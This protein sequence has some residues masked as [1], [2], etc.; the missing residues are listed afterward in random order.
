MQ[1]GRTAPIVGWA[2]CEEGGGKLQLIRMAVIDGKSARKVDVAVALWKER[3]PPEDPKTNS[4]AEV[5][6]TL[7]CE[8]GDLGIQFKEG[9]P[10]V[11]ASVAEGGKAEALGIQKDWVL[12]KLNNKEHG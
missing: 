12:K 6:T 2:V 1:L 5:E 11:V 3:Y 8:A 7:T 4:G 9:Q 10:G